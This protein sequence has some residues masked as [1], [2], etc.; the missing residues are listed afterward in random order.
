MANRLG[1]FIAIRN[2]KRQTDESWDDN[3]KVITNTQIYVHCQFA[4]YSRWST[5]PAICLIRYS[6][7]FALSV[8]EPSPEMLCMSQLAARQLKRQLISINKR[9]AG[10]ES[11]EAEEEI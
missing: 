7:R 9:M 1:Q 10:G 4:K 3:K 6:V 11:E 5:R 8:G 2:G